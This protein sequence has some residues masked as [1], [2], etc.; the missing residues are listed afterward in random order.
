[1]RQNL[2]KIWRSIDFPGG[3][4]FTRTS[5]IPKNGGLWGCKISPPTT[6]FYLITPNISIEPGPL[7]SLNPSKLVPV[8]LATFRGPSDERINYDPPGKLMDQQIVAVF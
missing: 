8:I 1:M 5:E 2:A 4:E 7:I 6:R 3:S